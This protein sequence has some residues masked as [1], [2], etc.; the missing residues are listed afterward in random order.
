MH[1]FSWTAG[2]VF[3]LFVLCRCQSVLAQGETPNDPAY[4]RYPAD[5]HQE[6]LFLLDMEQAWKLEKGS[7]QVLVAV[8]DLAFNVEHPDLKGKLWSNPREVPDNGQDDDGNGCV[9]DV[10]GWDFLDN[11]ATL[12]GPQAEHGNHVAGILAAQTN[13]GTGIA[14]MAPNCPLMLVKVGLAG[15][16][17]DGAI[18]ARAVRYCVDNGARL[19]CMN[20][21]L[22]EHFPG[23]H[24]PVGGELKAACDD[25]YRR[26]ALVVSCTT[27]NDGRYYPMCFQCGYDS[28]MGTG[29]SDLLGKPSN[30]YGGSLAC[31]VIAPGGQDDAGNRHSKESIYSCYQLAGTQYHYW[32]GGCM[33]TPHVV[34]LLA[35]VLSHYEG[36]DVEQARQIVRNTAK[37]EKPGFDVRWGN[38]LIQPVAALSLTPEQIAAKPV[39]EAPTPVERTGVQDSPVYAVKVRNEGA[40]DARVRLSL[41]QQGRGLANR[42][43]TAAGLETTEIG[44]PAQGLPPAGELTVQMEPL[45]MARPRVYDDVLEIKLRVADEDVALRP[46]TEG[47]DVVVVRVHNEGSVD[48][49]RVAVILH[50]HEPAV[51]QRTGAASRMIE[52][53]VVAVPAAGAAAAEFFIEDRSVL[54]DLWVEIEQLDVGAPHVPRDRGKARLPV[55]EVVRLRAEAGNRSLTT[56]ATAQ[57]EVKPIAHFKLDEG[58]SDRVTDSLEHKLT[59]TIQGARWTTVGEEL[60]LAFDGTSAGVEIPDH[61]CL[62]GMK[63]LRIDARVR[64]DQPLETIEPIAY[65][66]RSG[67]ESASFGLA[68]LGGHPYVLIRTDQTGYTELHCKDLAVA[69]GQWHTVSLLYTGAVL[70]ALVDG[71]PSELAEVAYG[72]IDHCPQPLRLGSATDKAG[73][74]VSFFRGQMSE[75]KIGVP[76]AEPL[77]TAIPGR[78]ETDR[79]V[80]LLLPG[81]AETLFLEMAQPG[82]CQI[83]ATILEAPDA[84]EVQLTVRS[85]ES[86]GEPIRGTLSRQRPAWDGE[87]GKGRHVL[88]LEA[89][90][91]KVGSSRIRENSEPTVAACAR[92]TLPNSHEFGYIAYRLKIEGVADVWQTMFRATDRGAGARADYVAWLSTPAPGKGAFEVFNCSEGARFLFLAP[93][94]AVQSVIQTGGVMGDSSGQPRGG[95]G[96]WRQHTFATGAVPCGAW[97]YYPSD[98]NASGDYAIRG[99]SSMTIHWRRPDDEQVLTK[100]AESPTMRVRQLRIRGGETTRENRRQRYEEAI[101]AGLAFMTALTEKRDD[102]Y[103]M[104]ERWL[105]DRQEPRIYWGNDGQMLCARTFYHTF[106]RTHDPDHE[107]VALGIAR[108]V[109]A[110][111]QLD[112]KQL[113]YGALPYG[114]MGHERQVSWGSSNNIRTPDLE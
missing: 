99:N 68:L 5:P 23:W 57:D 2:T 73:K 82:K 4:R 98:I 17:R 67:R 110:Y 11:D 97:F 21:G 15:C 54:S 48:A 85:E 25:A 112:P 74:L 34:G 78:L 39:L 92:E 1:N 70:T 95:A 96:V 22:S 80:R 44:F 65:K 36:I 13:N 53:Q 29:A 101:R 91:R 89:Q 100:F 59:G 111:Q 45:G 50:H 94:G 8:V 105:V 19:I 32:S 24:V 38:G 75:V 46:G 79:V 103:W 20:H 62:S 18:M 40:L 108:R 86:D 16:L 76:E 93:R 106:Q 41:L 61:R 66:W 109:A 37:G 3:W 43:A 7:P 55:A 27:S 114:L 10:H 51:A 35:L 12:D 58:T 87:L 49:E 26:G 6:G 31:E 14:G 28:V 102:G 42:E 72:A 113:R 47:P 104:L 88:K 30:I 71:R 69:P 63:A 52:V 60:C 77:T 107:A 81:E 33:A 64:F 90:P 9:D 84:A 83:V 56:S